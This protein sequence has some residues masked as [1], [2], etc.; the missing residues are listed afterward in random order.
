MTKNL[1]TSMLAE[2][3]TSG[4]SLTLAARAIDC[5]AIMKD[6]TSVILNKSEE[7]QPIKNLYN[8]DCSLTPQTDI[9]TQ[10]VSGRGKLYGFTICTQLD[11]GSVALYLV[12]KR[13]VPP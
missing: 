7:S 5:V 9:A 1:Y 13:E 4:F 12:G 8:T 2:R 11:I 6:D 10:S 3:L